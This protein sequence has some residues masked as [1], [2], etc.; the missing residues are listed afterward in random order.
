VYLTVFKLFRELYAPIAAAVSAV[1]HFARISQRY[2]WGHEG[3]SEKAGHDI[4]LGCQPIFFEIVIGDWDAV[5]SF[6]YGNFLEGPSM[7]AHRLR[8][9]VHVA[10]GRI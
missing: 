3:I 8:M 7:Y 2:S 5:Y 9:V 4:M 6:V 1:Q 10:Q